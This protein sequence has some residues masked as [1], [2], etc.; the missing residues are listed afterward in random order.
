[1]DTAR[2]CHENY[3]IEQNNLYTTRGF[4]AYNKFSTRT[5][6]INFRQSKKQNVFKRTKTAEAFALR[7]L[8]R[9]Q[10]RQARSIESGHRIQSILCR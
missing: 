1:M 7:P 8:N 10:S 9:T 2:R 3:V 5:G 4:W 6:K